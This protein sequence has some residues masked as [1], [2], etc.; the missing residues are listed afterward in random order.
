LHLCPV[1]RLQLNNDDVKVPS[2]FSDFRVLANL[3]AAPTLTIA[4][5]V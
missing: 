4:N 3:N 5:I 1:V 2:T